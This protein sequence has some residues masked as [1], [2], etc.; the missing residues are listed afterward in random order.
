[1]PDDSKLDLDALPV[2]MERRVEG[3][4]SISLEMEDNSLEKIMKTLIS[5][6]YL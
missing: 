4:D 5:M 2:G 1:M 3:Y 6:G